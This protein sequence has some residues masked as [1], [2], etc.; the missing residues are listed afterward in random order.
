MLPEVHP[1]AMA[2]ARLA[3]PRLA[4]GE[5]V[6]AALAAPL[7]IRDKFG[8]FYRAMFGEQT[9]KE[10]MSVVFLE[11]AWDMSWCDPCGEGCQNS[12]SRLMLDPRRCDC[13]VAGAARA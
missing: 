4:A 1:T 7:Y 3:A 8:D 13:V 6:D 9:R 5:G 2:V 11:Y 10:D 12:D